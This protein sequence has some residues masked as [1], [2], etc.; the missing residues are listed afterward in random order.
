MEY[1]GEVALDYSVMKNQAE[2]SRLSANTVLTNNK[3]EYS[4]FKVV[5]PKASNNNN[6]ITTTPDYG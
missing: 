2:M 3:S 6:N 1:G 4:A 5:Q